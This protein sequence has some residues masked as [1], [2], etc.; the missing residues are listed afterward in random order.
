M[1]GILYYLLTFAESLTSVFGYRGA[2]EQ[3]RYVVI[4]PIGPNAEIRLYEPRVAVEAAITAR[5]RQQAASEAFGL[6]FRYIS[7]ANQ[8][9]QTISMTAPVR[10]DPAPERIAMTAPVQT[11][12]EGGSITMRFFL[13]RD[14]A[15]KGAPA[16]TDP[17]LHIVDVP[18][19]TLAVLRYSGIDS[20]A[21]HQQK[22]ADLLAL[23]QKT[24]W[25]PLGPVFRLNY[26]PPFTIPPFRR[27]EAAVAVTR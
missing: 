14:V 23:L 16:P 9:S 15:Q 24:D 19:T 6:L 7:G 3:P 8:G 10:T 22:A 20:L 21:R 11:T 12:G 13:P 17:R 26:D 25:K 5:D 4:Q 1:S 18:Q 2:Y 27:N